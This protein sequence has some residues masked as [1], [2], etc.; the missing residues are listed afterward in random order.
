MDKICRFRDQKLIERF[1]RSSQLI[2]I[3]EGATEQFIKRYRDSKKPEGALGALF[4][5]LHFEYSHFIHNN[6]NELLHQVIEEPLQFLNAAK[7]C[8]YGIVRDQIKLSG[9]TGENNGLK[10]IDIDQLHIQ[11]RFNGLPLQKNL[12]FAH[13][14]NC[15]PP[16]LS[17][18]TGIL[19]AISEPQWAMSDFLDLLKIY[20]FYFPHK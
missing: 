18:T 6:A 10:S 4:V 1:V 15:L 2:K 13:Y 9:S 12:H 14:K 17:W 16:G 5:P 19:S 3:I 11:L 8:V 7:Y 20:F